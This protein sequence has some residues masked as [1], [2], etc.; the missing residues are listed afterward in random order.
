[1]RS[2]SAFV[3]VSLAM[4]ASLALAKADDDDV[5][6]AEFS[7]KDTD[8]KV[9]QPL[10]ANDG[11]GSG[12]Q[13]LRKVHATFR[14][15]KLAD[16]KARFE[17]TVEAV[18]SQMRANLARAPSDPKRGEIA[19]IDRLA[20]EIAA[21]RRL[22]QQ[23]RRRNEV[24]RRRQGRRHRAQR[25]RIARLRR[26]Q[27]KHPRLYRAN[28]IRRTHLHAHQHARANRIRAQAQRRRAAVRRQ[29]RNRLA[30]ILRRARTELKAEQQQSANLKTTNDN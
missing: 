3:L 15:V 27:R 16:T 8:K 30:T 7:P 29:A 1:M 14:R 21:S 5:K 9:A 26:V 24:A 18:K 6:K 12:P 20:N 23:I 25:A 22:D 28:R 13:A 4:A 19:S 17:K 2:L 11:F 10:A